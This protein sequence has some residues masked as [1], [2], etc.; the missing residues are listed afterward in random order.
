MTDLITFDPNKPELR[1]ELAA[2]SGV[3]IVIAHTCRHSRNTETTL[4]RL[5]HPV[6]CPAPAAAAAENWAA[7]KGRRID[8]PQNC[9]EPPVAWLDIEPTARSVNSPVGWVEWKTDRH[10]L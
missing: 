4:I 3:R 1:P 5:A 7:A 2:I 8:I 10:E 6:D 9:E